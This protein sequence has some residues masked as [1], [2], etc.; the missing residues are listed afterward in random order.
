MALRGFV[1]SKMRREKT[2]ILD[3]TLSPDLL[4]NIQIHM[5]WIKLFKL[6]ALPIAEPFLLATSWVGWY[7][8]VSIAGMVEKNQ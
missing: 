8:R 2:G 6:I 4:Y 5:I 7:P 3:L 1:L